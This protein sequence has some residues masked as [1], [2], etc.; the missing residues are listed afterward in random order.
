MSTVVQRTYRPQIPPGLVGMIVDETRASVSTYQIETAAGVGFGVAVSQGVGDTGIV[1]GGAT[2]FI[3]LTVRDV[4][5][6]RVPLDPLSALVAEQVPVDTYPQTANVGVMHTGHMW[7]VA[8]ANVAA[9][10]PLFYVA[11]DG[12]LTNIITGTAAIGY[13]DFTTNPVDGQT[14][15]LQGSAITFKA[16]GATGLQSNIGPTLGDTLSALAAMINASADVNLVLLTVRAY[17]PSPGGSGQGS[18]AYRLMVASKAVGVAGNA[19]TLATNVP[20]ATVSG[21]VLAG[22]A[23]AAIAVT[24]GFW[25]TSAIAGDLAQV[26]LGI[27]R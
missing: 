21:G 18:G 17:P 24:G 5:Q 23:A 1:V 7:V 14:I 4:T 19:Y 3:G 13:V 8:H 15:T 6:D 27:Q 11:A 25:L 2:K 20:G 9:S 22:G 26:S 16:S 10:D 12:S